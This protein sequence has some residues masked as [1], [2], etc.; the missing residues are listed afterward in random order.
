MPNKKNIS[1]YIIILAVVLMIGFTIKVENTINQ[2]EQNVTL[3]EANNTKYLRTAETLQK[4]IDET[5]EENSILGKRI[6]DIEERLVILDDIIKEQNLLISY[7]ESKELREKHI[8]VPIYTANLNTNEREILYYISIPKQFSLEEKLNIISEKLSKYCY[9]NLPIELLRIENNE[10]KK[11]A[12][13]NLRELDENKGISEVEKIKGKTWR[14]YYFQGSTGGAITSTN[15]IETFLQKDYRGE[16]IDGVR[17]IYN[18]D[19]DTWWQHVEKLFETN[20]R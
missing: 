13:I 4:E 12:V 6:E 18:N 14:T 2:L 15:L 9:E 5:T 20:Y 17:F 19:P 1:G 7:H 10:G 8:V 3:L 16:W 11:I